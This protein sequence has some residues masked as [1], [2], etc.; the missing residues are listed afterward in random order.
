MEIDSLFREEF[1]KLFL[2]F[3]GSLWNAQE[4]ACRK[5]KMRSGGWYGRG[6]ED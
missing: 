5:L 3:M 6:G 4:M 1:D 2:C